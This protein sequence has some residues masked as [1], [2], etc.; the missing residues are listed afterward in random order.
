MM[1]KDSPILD[2]HG[3]AHKN[4]LNELINFYFW[5]GNGSSTIITGKSVKMKEIVI[6]WLE[7]NGF[8]YET[9]TNND[10]RIVVYEQL[11]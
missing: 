1:K 11:S 4:I 5:E 6:E 8:F 9:P 7:E 10:G 3:I 2:L